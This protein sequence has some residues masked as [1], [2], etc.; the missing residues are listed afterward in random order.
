MLANL[1]SARMR[2]VAIRRSTE[3][4]K[5]DASRDA[6]AQQ[7]A[8]EAGAGK[9]TG[10]REPNQ[11]W[12]AP[13]KGTDMDSEG[14][15]K[16]PA[17][18]DRNQAL[19]ML[20][21]ARGKE[22]LRSATLLPLTERVCHPLIRTGE[23]DAGTERHEVLPV[24]YL[25]EV[26]PFGPW[27]CLPFWRSPRTFRRHPAGW[28]RTQPSNSQYA[29]LC[30]RNGTIYGEA[31]KLRP[32]PPQCRYPHIETHGLPA[33]FARGLPHPDRGKRKRSVFVF[34]GTVT[35]GQGR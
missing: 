34:S 23:H 21:E 33:R 20:D 11:G 26:A 25:E 22:S 2:L 1:Q 19:R 6:T 24:G 5:G 15:G 9:R 4:K 17:A 8:P 31:Q 28:T 29:G 7:R 32:H 27:C 30:R 18:M 35:P 12:R 14:A 16:R 3:G 10:Q 13:G